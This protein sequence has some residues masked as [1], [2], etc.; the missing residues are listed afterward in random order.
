MFIIVAIVL[1]VLVVLFFTFRGTIQ[2]Q[3]IPSFVEPIE[4]SFLVCLE[5]NTAL[6]ISLLELSGGNLQDVEFEPGSEYMPFSSHLKFMNDEIP[7]WFYISRGNIE[8]ENI[9]SIEYME[10]QLENYVV[11]NLEDCAFEEFYGQDY[12]LSKGSADAEVKINNN[13]VEIELTMDLSVSKGEDSFVVNNHQVVIN[14]K[15]GSLYKDAIEIYGQEQE[16]LFL[17]DFGVDT[18]RLY[19]PVDG[20]E[21]KCSPMVWEAEEVFTDLKEAIEVNTLA[22]KTSGSKKDYF[23]IDSSLDSNARFIYSKDWPFSFEV[24]PNEGSSLVAKPVGNQPGLGILG[25]CYVTYHYVYNLAYP[26]LVQVYEG[27]EVFQF[28]LAVVIKGNLPR[29]A[30]GGES[31]LKN[32]YDVCKDKLSSTEISVSDYNGNPIVADVDFEC[33]GSRCDVGTTSSEGNLFTSIPQ[34]VNGFLVVNSEGYKESRALYS[35]VDYGST[36]ILLEEEFEKLISINL[37]SRHYTGPAIVS[38][39]SGDSVQTIAYP[40]TSE[41]FLSEGAYEVHVQIYGDSAL[42]FASNTREQCM[43][44]PS[45]G[46]GGAFGATQKECFTIEMPEQIISRVLIGGG[47]GTSSFS[48]YDLQSTSKVVLNVESLP[49]PKSIEELQT[50]YISFESKSIGVSLQ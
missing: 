44:I 39:F 36:T 50:N 40:E 35:S 14:S 27:D 45:S 21:I 18:L 7:Y 22:L 5:D 3:T 10:A 4:N 9:P 30:A 29:E 15:L 13:N 32:S 26:T 48:E 20:V 12:D 24:S 19:A 34:C 25:F 41:V 17:E 31:Y 33:F 37:N 38:F 43:D 1:V 49:T 23:V 6:G 28:P 11:E 42:T 16:T 47:T 8:K 2:K 46:I